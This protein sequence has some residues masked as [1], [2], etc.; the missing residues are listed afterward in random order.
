[1]S[2]PTSIGAAILRHAESRP[3]STAVVATGFAPLSYR[4]LSDYLARCAA[5]LRESG[6]DRDARVA[7][8]LPSG[9]DG[10]LAIVATACA[11]VAVPIDTQ[12]TAPEIDGRLESLRPRAVIVPADGPSPAREAAMGR[13]V[14]VIEAVREDRGKLGL[15]SERVRRSAPRRRLKN[16][17]L[18][19]PPLFCRLRAPPPVRS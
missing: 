10:A 4:G 15:E 11:A 18:P 1:M 19:P 6:L 9:A 14:A 2:D 7:V 12:L 16:P 17:T 5:R 8:A 13:G 3:D